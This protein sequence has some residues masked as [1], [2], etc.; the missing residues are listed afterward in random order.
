MTGKLTVADY[1]LAETAPHR[2]R[3]ARGKAL[4]A[5]TLEAVAAGEVTIEDL[6][7]TADALR[8][9]SEIARAAGRLTLAQ[10]FDRGAELVAVPQDLIMATYEMLRPGR[11]PNRQGLLDQAAMLRRDFGAEQIARFLEVAADH[12]LRRGLVGE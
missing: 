6:R 4:D 1:P 11:V 3:G 7:I 8:S 10:N 2:I 12:Y 5:L 9:Q